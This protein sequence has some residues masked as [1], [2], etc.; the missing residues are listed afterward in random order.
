[1]YTTPRLYSNGN[2]AM[3]Q[4]TAPGTVHISPGDQP[5]PYAQQYAPQQYAMVTPSVGRPPPMMPMP[6]SMRVYQQPPPAQ[7]QRV[8]VEPPKTEGAPCVHPNP[9]RR[10]SISGYCSHESHPSQQQPEKQPQTV[11]CVG[12]GAPPSQPRYSVATRASQSTRASVSDIP[13][14]INTY[15]QLYQLERGNVQRDLEAK[16]T[17]I[18]SLRNQNE[19]LKHAMRTGPRADPHLHGLFQSKDQEIQELFS[20][21]DEEIRILHQK[22]DLQA[23]LIEELKQE[24][25]QHTFGGGSGGLGSRDKINKLTGEVE[26][27]KRNNTLMSQEMSK[28]DRILQRMKDYVPGDCEL[29]NVLPFDPDVVHEMDSHMDGLVLENRQ[30][31]DVIISKDRQLSVLSSID[32]GMNES[33]AL[34]LGAQAISMAQNSMELKEKLKTV[35]SELQ[36]CEEDRRGLQ[37]K[38]EDTF[39]KLAARKRENAN[40]VESIAE[41]DLKLTRADTLLQQRDKEISVIKDEAKH[42]LK[43]ERERSCRLATE[44]DIATTQHEKLRSELTLR[45]EQIMKLKGDLIRSD[46]TLKSYDTRIKSLSHEMN[47][48][49]NHLQRMVKQAVAKDQYVNEVEKRLKENE[50]KRQAS[51]LQE[52]AKSRQ[53][54]NDY[55]NK[56]EGIYQTLVER[57]RE[58]S[59]MKND[60]GSKVEQV[61]AVRQML[62]SAAGDVHKVCTSLSDDGPPIYPTGGK[63]DYGHD[64]GTYRH[65]SSSKDRS[66]LNSPRHRTSESAY[67]HPR[68]M[69]HDGTLR[70]DKGKV[71]YQYSAKNGTVKVKSK[72]GESHAS[73]VEPEKPPPSSQTVLNQ[74]LGEYVPVRGDEIDAVV[75]DLV[76]QDAFR[77]HRVLLCRL[78][79]GVYLYGTKRIQMRLNPKTRELEGRG[80]EDTSTPY[81]DIKAFLENV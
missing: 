1:M 35:E 37:D 31:K 79:P 4:V 3:A 27:L 59:R 38:F 32:P 73:Q 64:H 19:E 55:Y 71:V 47:E 75:G 70:N 12:Q 2:Q 33:S 62:T 39:Q 58:I 7:V 21:K 60:L 36:T 28:R 57:E 81:Q 23:R 61:E 48:L 66:R 68:T 76:Q 22:G 54:Q 74:L 25:Q 45:D 8:M 49:Q 16:E 24:I 44:V 50:A 18:R 9:N 78:S 63:Y 5:S 52:F 51:Y 53:L 40:L 17:E 56:E 15:D 26:A 80:S 42:A 72:F 30:L 43:S 46:K 77:N 6:E 20:C 67:D 41:R 14:V 65:D 10:G 11:S 29:Q 13:A 69:T 34:Q